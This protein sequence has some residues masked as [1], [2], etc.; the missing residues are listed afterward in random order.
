MRVRWK[1]LLI[2]SSIWLVSE[3]L[4]TLVGLDDLADYGEFIF[5]KYSID[6]PPPIVYIV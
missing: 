5:Q 3:I 6:S 4:L 2:Q 1:T